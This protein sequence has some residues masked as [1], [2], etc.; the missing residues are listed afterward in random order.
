[1]GKRHLHHLWT[2]LRAISLWYLL[3]MCLVS[4]CVCI[5][6]L[7]QNNL[8]MIRLRNQVFAADQQNGNVEGALKNLREFVY[9]HMNTN[10]D[11]GSGIRP[12]IQLKY[13]YERLVQAEKDR[14]SAANSKIYNDAQTIC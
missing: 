8:T 3:A 10:L 6:S 1:M 12:P 5:Y 4:G 2:R 9:A 7:R 11:S 14:V 13:R